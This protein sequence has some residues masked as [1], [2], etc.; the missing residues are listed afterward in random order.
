MCLFGCVFVDVNVCVQCSADIL[1]IGRFIFLINNSGDN[2]TSFFS[3]PF[4]V[5][6]FLQYYLLIFTISLVFF[7]S[8]EN[9]FIKQLHR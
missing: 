9:I 5:C 3:P 4:L 7:S 1:I 2:I 6:I 8:S